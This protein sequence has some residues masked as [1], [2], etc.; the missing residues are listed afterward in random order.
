L[1]QALILAKFP[2]EGQTKKFFEG[3]HRTLEITK[4]GDWS[5]VYR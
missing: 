5:I 3:T 4:D 1:L 2:E